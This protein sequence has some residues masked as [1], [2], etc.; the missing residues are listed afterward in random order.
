MTYDIPDA[1]VE[2]I[3]DWGTNFRSTRHGAR[4][5]VGLPALAIELGYGNGKGPAASRALHMALAAGRMP[6]DR[7]HR[8]AFL[9]HQTSS[10]TWGALRACFP[11]DDWS[12]ICRAVDILRDFDQPERG[13]V[14]LVPQR[15]KG[16]PVEKLRA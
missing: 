1:A 7:L 15:R 8:L 6:S 13:E 9:V 16:R 2:V 11:S 14:S 3:R 5:H 10:A 4:R 12:R